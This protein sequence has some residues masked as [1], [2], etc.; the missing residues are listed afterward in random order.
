[1]DDAEGDDV[2]AQR[3]RLYRLVTQL[4]HAHEVHDALLDE[5]TQAEQV[6]ADLLTA[7]SDAERTLLVLEVEVLDAAYAVI[8]ADNR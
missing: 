1:M 5:I 4:L 6:S 7:L 3:S 8:A 2:G